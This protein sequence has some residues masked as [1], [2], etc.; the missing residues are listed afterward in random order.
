MQVFGAVQMPPLTQVC[1][2]TG[3]LH[4]GP[5]HMDGHVQVLGAVQLPPLPQVCAQTG[6]VQLASV[7][8]N[9]QVHVSG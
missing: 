2:H 9:A 7:Q 4:S 8:P 6:V 3:T 1:W 5:C